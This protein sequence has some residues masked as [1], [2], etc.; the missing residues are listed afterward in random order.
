MASRAVSLQA[1]D[2][3]S[4]PE[5]LCCRGVAASGHRVGQ[6]LELRCKPL[7]VDAR[8]GGHAT[9]P[10]AQRQQQATSSEDPGRLPQMAPC[11][12]HRQ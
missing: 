4:V 10:T 7:P 11:E 6:L 9:I 1:N 5:R 12:V 2:L 8:A 3:R